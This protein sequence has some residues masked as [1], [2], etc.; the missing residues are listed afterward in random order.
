MALVWKQL[1]KYELK[2]ISAGNL[3]LLLSIDT[4]TLELSAPNNIHTNKRNR[5]SSRRRNILSETQ[6]KICDTVYFFQ[7]NRHISVITTQAVVIRIPHRYCVTM[8]NKTE[9]NHYAAFE[10]L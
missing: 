9:R 4:T 7:Q 2:Q 1:T 10:M 8:H 5:L 3:F 6:S